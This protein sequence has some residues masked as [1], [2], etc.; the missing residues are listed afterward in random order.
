MN[1]SKVMN[2]STIVKSLMNGVACYALYVLLQVLAKGRALA[3]TLASPYTILLAV[4]AILG[5]F[6]GYVIKANRE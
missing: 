1:M 2:K 5:S 4:S 6:I 3:E